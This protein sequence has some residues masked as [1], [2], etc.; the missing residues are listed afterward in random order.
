[1]LTFALGGAA[2]LPPRPPAEN[3]RPEP[4]PQF[5]DAAT[6]AQGAQ[7]FTHSCLYCHGGSA[8]GTG[9]IPDLRHSPLIGNKQAWNSVVSD[10]ILS[11]KGMVS[12]RAAYSPAEI[13]S[14]RAYVIERAQIEKRLEPPS[15]SVK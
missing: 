4:P 11:D 1:V 3:L 9:V 12:F 8:K 13:E 14:I 10:G 2:T 6:I 5:A 15:S 7:N